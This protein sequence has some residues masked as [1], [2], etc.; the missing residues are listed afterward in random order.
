ML[1]VLNEVNKK[2]YGE[3]DIHTYSTKHNHAR[4]GKNQIKKTNEKKNIV[5][6]YLIVIKRK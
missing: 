5:I 1:N 3:I 6:E 2:Y 4:Q